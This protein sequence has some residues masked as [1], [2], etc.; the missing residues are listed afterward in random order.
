[1]ST[2]A[3]VVLAAL[4]IGVAREYLYLDPQ[5][6]MAQETTDEL[7]AARPDYRETESILYA[8]PAR[9]TAAAEALEPQR[10]GVTDVY[11]I[12]FAGDGSQRVFRRE[13]LFGQKVF[14]MRMDSATRSLVLINDHTDRETHPLATLSGLRHSLNLI[15]KQMNTDEDVLALL[16]TSH[17]SRERGLSVDTG[18]TLWGDDVSPQ[19][20]RSA[21]DA[22]GIKWRIVLV[23][24]C[25][26]GVFIEP[27]KS[28]NTLVMTAADPEHN[29]FGCADDRHLTYFGE[30]FLEDAMLEAASLEQAFELA[31]LSISAREQAEKKTPSN[32]QIFVGESMRQKLVELPLQA[33]Q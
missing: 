10:P 28:K 7:E 3:V 22:S 14:G 5:L 32:P 27:L 6:W 9:I 13:A 24:A 11:Y 8:E 31:K 16:L 19:E 4:G 15:G 26:A 23:S 20:L 12:G 1:V 18:V 25:Y 33:S 17:G 29:S 2:F 30:A 21:L